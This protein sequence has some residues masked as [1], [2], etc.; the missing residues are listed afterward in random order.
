[1]EMYFFC[2]IEY[3]GYELVTPSVLR[4]PRKQTMRVAMS[5]SAASMASPE[6]IPSAKTACVST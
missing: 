2:A 6:E 4:V 5:P 3:V 1:M